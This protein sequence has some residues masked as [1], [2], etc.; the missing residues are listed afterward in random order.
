[1]W[2]S[3]KESACQCRR[4]KRCG[5]DP[6]VRKTPLRGKWQPTPVFLP[7]KFYRQRSL[8]GYI[9]ST[10]SQ[11]VRHAHEH[12]RTCMWLVVIFLDI[13]P[14]FITQVP[15]L[16]PD[17]SVQFSSV[18][19]SCLTLCN[20]MDCSMLG[21]PAHHQLPEPTQTHVHWVSDAIQPS[22]PLL[23]P[24]PPAL[25]LSQHQG[26]FKWVRSLHQ[27]AKVLEFQL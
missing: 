25:S 17:G 1:M 27:V 13:N 8:T 7:G 19:Q 4:G 15:S 9:Q 12:A 26:L 20:S 2:Q 24:S 10:G 23:P 16:D 21:L 14:T 11:R 3:G 5:F 18:V 6:W 22:H